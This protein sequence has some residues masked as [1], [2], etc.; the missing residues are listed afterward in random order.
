MMMP[1]CA[2]STPAVQEPVWSPLGNSV[3]S[4]PKYHTLPASSCAYQSSVSS[5]RTPPS[6]T[7]S[8][9][10]MVATPSIVGLLCVTVT[11]STTGVFLNVPS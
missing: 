11:T 4:S 2:P 1:G 5:V 3:D 9:I 8:R 10:S 7:W 6:V